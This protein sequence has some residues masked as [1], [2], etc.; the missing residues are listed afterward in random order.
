MHRLEFGEKWLGVVVQDFVGYCKAGTEGEPGVVSR[1]LRA[2]AGVLQVS[3][4]S[5]QCAV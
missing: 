4:I 3:N 1:Q 5:T 2:G